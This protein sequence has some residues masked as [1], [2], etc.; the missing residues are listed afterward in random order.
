MDQ[1]EEEWEGRQAWNDEGSGV[2]CN[3]DISK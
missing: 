2:A 3:G 1:G